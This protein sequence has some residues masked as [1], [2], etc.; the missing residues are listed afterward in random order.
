MTVPTT[1]TDFSFP[2]AAL[3]DLV[4]ACPTF[5]AEV[6]AQDSQTAHQR[7]K[8]PFASD[9]RDDNGKLMDPRPRA[10][11]NR[12]PNYQRDKMGTA[13]GSTSGDLL[14]SFEF[15]PKSM[16]NGDPNLEQADFEETIGNIL[17]EMEARSAQ[18]KAAGEAILTSDQITHLNVT[19]IVLVF[20]PAECERRNEQDELFYGVTFLIE[21]EG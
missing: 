17:G 16:W 21:F 15:L 18:D 7:I 10:T 9:R 5:R 19:S 1:N 2:R 14:L 4:A 13:F 11:I 8:Q 12:G 3:A 6:G 20:G